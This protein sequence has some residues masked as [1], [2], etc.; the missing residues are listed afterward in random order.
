MLSVESS[1]YST[2][3]FWP[4]RSWNTCQYSRWSQQKICLRNSKLCLMHNFFTGCA[5]TSS[6]CNRAATHFHVLPFIPTLL[7]KT[8]KTPGFWHH[9]IPV[10]SV[11][12]VCFVCHLHFFTIMYKPSPMP[13]KDYN[14]FEKIINLCLCTAST[15]QKVTLFFPHLWEECAYVVTAS[16]G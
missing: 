11:F 16:G 7:C 12:W 9:P 3:W 1:E 8:G 4:P 10:L 6:F 5:F 13:W 2:A 14:N 15:E